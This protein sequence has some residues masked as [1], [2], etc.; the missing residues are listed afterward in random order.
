MN[1]WA[2]TLLAALALGA[3][4]CDVEPFCVSGCDEDAPG[5]D[6]GLPDADAG[7]GGGTMGR[8]A[9]CLGG[10]EI[11]NE[12]DDDCDGEIDEGT[13]FLSDPDNCGSCGNR[14]VI[15]NV[16][17]TCEEGTCVD[18]GC[19]EGYA[20]L[21][22]T[23]E[24]CEYRCPIF[25]V[26]AEG[27]NGLDDD[28]DGVVDEDL[29]PPAN[30]CR[31]TAGTPCA[32]AA[33]ICDTRGGVTSWYCSYGA[34]VEFEPGVPNGIVLEEMLCDGL[35]GDCDGVADDGFAELG[36]VCDNGMLGACRDAGLVACDPGDPTGTV[37]D[38][39]LGVDPVPGAPLAETCNRVDDNCDGI[40]DN[41]DPTDPDRVLDDMVRVTRGGLDFWIYTYEASRP[42]ATDVDPGVASNRSCSQPGVLPWTT[43]GFAA[44]EAACAAAGHRL[45]TAAEWQAA[46]EGASGTTYPYGTDYEAL[47]CNGADQ[48]PAA[49]RGL[50]ATGALAMCA[51]AGGVQDLSGN[52]KEWTDDPRDIVG[53]SQIYV[54][55]GGSYDSPRLGLT[56]QTDLS[57]ATE[58]TALPS[59]GF[60]CCSDSGP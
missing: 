38:F 53:G 24:G 54:V 45:C 2:T 17:T 50:M 27:C 28:C 11:C 15:P 13:D 19:L 26:Q 7:D 57:R 34:D 37:C 39:T 10:E 4:G 52:A 47:S 1:R 35:D 33:P 20:D 42:G 36:N 51:S 6:G 49:S 59:L 58:D 9:G 41:P 43:V 31:N 5:A 25:P 22:D 29:T 32:G 55:R 46:C 14:C 23:D 60:R 16:D 40:V 3:I 56:C 30:F 44:A 48:G 12:V 8:D 18:R 21:D